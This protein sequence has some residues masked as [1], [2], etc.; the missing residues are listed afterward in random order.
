VTRSDVLRVAG[1]AGVDPR[2]VTAY[3]AGTRV[4]KITALSIDEAIVKLGIVDTHTRT[5]AK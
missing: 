1:E 5:E 3:L 4:R 2:T